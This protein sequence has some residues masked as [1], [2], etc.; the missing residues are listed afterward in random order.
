MRILLWQIDAAAQI[1][2][3]ARVLTRLLEDHLSLFAPEL[4]FGV[5]AI[6]D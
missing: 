4:C 3:L 1:Y 5:V 2:A 6:F